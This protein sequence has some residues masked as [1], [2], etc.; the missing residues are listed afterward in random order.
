MYF[1]WP[2]NTGLTCPSQYQELEFWS[3]HK[4]I[5]AVKAGTQLC[6]QPSEGKT[7]VK[8]GFCS[9]R[10]KNTKLNFKNVDANI[11]LEVCDVWFEEAARYNEDE[12]I[13]INT[14]LI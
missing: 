1:A 13:Q 12:K 4:H 10:F 14:A 9:N 8:W 2:R 3:I 7:T 6:V 11:L 5:R